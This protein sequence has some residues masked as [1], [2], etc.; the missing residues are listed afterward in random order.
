MPRL[1]DDQR[2]VMV[3]TSLKVL[4]STLVYHQH[5]RPVGEP[6]SLGLLLSGRVKRHVMFV[7][8]P[9]SR[10]VSAWAD[11]FLT[12]PRTLDQEGFRGW[13]HV[14]RIY[15]Q[16][17]GLHNR[18][19]NK[20]I[21]EA[22]L[23]TT[24]PEFVNR[25]PALYWRDAHL[26]PQYWTMSIRYKGVVP[27]LPLRFD[28]IIRVEHM[29]ASSLRRELGIDVMGVRRNVTE[30]PSADELFTPQLRSIARRIYSR[31]FE[32]FGYE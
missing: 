25:L 21:G 6:A 22:L 31:D 4:Y 27:I 15:L 24:F 12:Y 30:H 20:V 17:I 18:A 8:N 7:R 23:A 14:H 9:Y 19:G 29:V 16:H 26:Q 2:G 32:K 3:T 10:L 28:Q 5:L 11:K 13:Q 1:F